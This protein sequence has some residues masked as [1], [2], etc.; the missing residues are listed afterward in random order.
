[1][2]FEG[3]KE[4]LKHLFLKKKLLAEA[5]PRHQAIRPALLI[6]GGVMR[7]IYSGGQ[8]RALEHFGL[9]DTFDVVAG[10]SAGAPT[11]AYFLAKQAA[12]GTTI[13]TEECA[14]SSFFSL[15]RFFVGGSPIMNTDYLAGVFSGSVSDK[16]LNVA[17][18]RKSR[19]R[20]YVGLTCAR[21]GEFCFY[22]TKSTNADVVEAI[23]ASLV[24]PGISKGTVWLNGRQWT[25]GVVSSRLPTRKF[26]E[27]FN[28]TDLLILTNCDGEREQKILFE[29]LLTP[30]L[31]TKFSDTVRD[32]ARRRDALFKDELNF[33]RQQRDARLAIIWTGKEVGRFERDPKKLKTAASSYENHL[34]RLLTESEVKC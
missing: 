29:H 13:Y 24:F 25:D 21:T 33:L 30:W 34:A 27:D 3:N 14:T 12:L 2:R 18:I 31:F 4:V 8:V 23:H 32:V 9:N 22:N 6:L 16:R 10:I 28:P 11:A 20:F 26:L 17:A 1:M 7:G 15:A 5:D 19:S